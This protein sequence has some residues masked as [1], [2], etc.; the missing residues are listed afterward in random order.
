[1]KKPI[2]KSKRYYVMTKPDNDWV[3][4]GGFD[5]LAGAK[6]YLRGYNGTARILCERMTEQV[7]WEQQKKRRKQWL[8][9]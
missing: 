3:C 6:L 2:T 4:A 7:V 1:M 8:S 5:T 9:L